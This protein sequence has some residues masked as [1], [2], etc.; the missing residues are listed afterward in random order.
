MFRSSAPGDRDAAHKITKIPFHGSPLGGRRAG[1]REVLP[2]KSRV[3]LKETP[4]SGINGCYGVNFSSWI[5][6]VC[7][8]GRPGPAVTQPTARESL[9]IGRM[10]A[11]TMSPT[12]RP[13]ISSMAGSIRRAIRLSWVSSSRS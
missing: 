10:R 3:A 7:E 5:W 1:K 2:R 4:Q 8:V 12:T 11:L 6:K 13:M 9:N